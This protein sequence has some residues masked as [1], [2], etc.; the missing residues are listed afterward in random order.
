MAKAHVIRPPSICDRLLEANK[1]EYKTRHLIDGQIVQCDQRISVVAGY[2]PDEVCGL[3]PFTFM[4]KADVRWVMVALR[5]S[6]CFTIKLSNI[7]VITI[8]YHL[9][10]SVRLQQQG[11]RVVLSTNRAQR[12]I[13]LFAHARLSGN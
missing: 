5:Q 4:H 9:V 3:S 7:C 2:M 13:H 1:L 8:M 12:R 6:E 11:G 10:I